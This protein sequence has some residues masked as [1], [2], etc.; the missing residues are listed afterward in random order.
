MKLAVLS[1]LVLLF[2]SQ[3]LGIVYPLLFRNIV[4]EIAKDNSGAFMLI[5][6]YV[7]VKFLSEFLN[8]IRQ[9]PFAYVQAQAEIEITKKVYR[10][11]QNQSM[12][13]HLNRETGK[14]IR[15]VQMGSSSFVSIMNIMMF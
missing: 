14:I 11:V 4:N 3:I 7:L 10:H 12:E 2:M 6:Y 13:F 5:S 1:L 15:A 8:N 9:W